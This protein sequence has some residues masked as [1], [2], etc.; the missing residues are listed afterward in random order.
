MNSTVKYEYQFSTFQQKQLLI[1]S[2]GKELILK[3]FK[4]FKI[5]VYN[6]PFFIDQ[7]FST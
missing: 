3:Y 6:F 1:L 2:K 7:N 5:W 4:F